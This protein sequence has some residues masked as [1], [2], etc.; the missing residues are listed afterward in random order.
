MKTLNAFLPAL[1]LAGACTEPI[2]SD[3]VATSEMV[4][5][6]D[7]TCD[8]NASVATASFT[9][10]SGLPVTYVQLGVSDTL[11][12]TGGDLSKEMGEVVVQDLITYVASFD[13]IDADTLF[14]FSLERDLDGGAPDSS[15]TLPPPFEITA[16]ATGS[17]FSR[18]NDDLVVT[19][20]GDADADDALTLVADGDCVDSYEEL[21]DADTGTATIPAGSLVSTTGHEAETCDVTVTIKRA[22]LGTLD[23]GYGG[24]TIGSKQYRTVQVSGSP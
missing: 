8:G 3:E 16:P 13:L 17:T 14:S 12:V 18:G 15:V 21:L 22:R 11:T 4:A 10:G 2:K 23:A 5:D 19:W 24:G 9:Y 7:V 20:T 6:L 1:L